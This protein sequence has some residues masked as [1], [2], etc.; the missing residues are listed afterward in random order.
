MEIIRKLSRF[1]NT[2][3]LLKYQYTFLHEKETENIIKKRN[4]PP[5][6]ATKPKKCLGSKLKRKNMISKQNGF[7]VLKNLKED[8]LKMPISCF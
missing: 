2:K 7:T 4:I 6:K 3:P 8:I 1:L 5:S